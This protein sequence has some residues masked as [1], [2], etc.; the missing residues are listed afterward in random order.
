MLLQRLKRLKYQICVERLILKLIWGKHKCHISVMF[1]TFALL[2]TSFCC[3]LF[4]CD[5]LMEPDRRMGTTYC[6]FR[7]TYSLNSH[8]GSGWKQAFIHITFCR[9]SR[10]SVKTCDTFGWKPGYWDVVAIEMEIMAHTLS[11]SS[12]AFV[13]L[14]SVL[15]TRRDGGSGV[16]KLISAAYLHTSAH[17]ANATW[18]GFQTRLDNPTSA[19]FEAYWGL[20]SPSGQSGLQTPKTHIW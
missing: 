3:P 6:W 7:W 13:A 10:N 9:F 8:N 17:L 18:S 5:G 20:N 4:F 15:H 1:S 16:K 2:I 14:H 11:L 12:W 19:L